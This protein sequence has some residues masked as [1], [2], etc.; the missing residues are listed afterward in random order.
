MDQRPGRHANPVLSQMVNCPR[1]HMMGVQLPALADP[2]TRQAEPPMPTG[3][4]C[5]AWACVRLPVWGVADKTQRSGPDRAHD[6]RQS[7]RAARPY[8][9]ARRDFV[10]D[11]YCPDQ[12]MSFT[13]KG[14]GISLSW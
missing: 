4:R 14:L 9:N 8:N 5:M 6:R 12:T 13:D 2:P 10:S 7:S 1:L 11:A 3:P